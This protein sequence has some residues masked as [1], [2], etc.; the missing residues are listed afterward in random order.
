[1]SQNPEQ[2]ALIKTMYNNVLN[3]LIGIENKLID[4][5]I[6][7]TTLEADNTRQH[8]DLRNGIGSITDRPQNSSST[9]GSRYPNAESIL[10]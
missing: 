4:L 9:Y 7:L 3:K 2:D 5:S 8:N 1:M 6:R 10:K